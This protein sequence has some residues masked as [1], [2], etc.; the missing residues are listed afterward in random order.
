M[1]FFNG[2]PWT[3]FQEQNLDWII[4]ELKKLQEQASDYE[5][6]KQ[7]VTNWIQD[8]DVPA[9]VAAQIQELIDNGTIEQMIQDIGI[10]QLFDGT[11]LLPEQFKTDNNTWD[12]AFHDLAGA[13]DQKIVIPA[14][15]Y[16]LTTDH[17]L[18][19]NVIS[20]A[21]IY[22]NKSAISPEQ[23]DVGQYAHLR[24]LNKW[25]D[26]V[27]NLQGACKHGTIIAFVT[28]ENS[29]NNVYIHEYTFSNMSFIRSLLV[30]PTSAI[31]G[32]NLAWDAVNNRYLVAPSYAVNTLYAVDQ[33]GNVQT[34]TIP[35]GDVID[36]VCAIE[37][38]FLIGR[39]NVS[40]F[41][42][43]SNLDVIREIPITSLPAVPNSNNYTGYQSMY[44]YKGSLFYMMS[45]FSL[46][47]EI[48][49]F[50]IWRTGL[51]NIDWKIFKEY[52][53]NDHFRGEEAEAVVLDDDV[54]YVFSYCRNYIHI[55]YFNTDI[56]Y[57]G[58]DG[59]INTIYVDET[60]SV[61]GIGTSSNPFNSLD[62]AMYYGR[63]G[64]GVNASNCVQ[65]TNA[66]IKNYKGR[67][68]G[69][70]LT[71]EGIW[72]GCDVFFNAGSFKTTNKL[73]LRQTRFCFDAGGGWTSDR[74]VGGYNNELIW[75]ELGSTIIFRGM[76]FTVNDASII[77]IRCQLNGIFMG[78]M[79][80]NA[81]NNIETYYGGYVFWQD[82]N[83][84]SKVN[85]RGQAL[86]VI[87]TT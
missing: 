70:N 79:S 23:F 7:Y 71:L 15:T 39:H 26:P 83:Q 67:I 38:G 20:N 16:P 24:S 2:W 69:T 9:E 36:V 31:H 25:A 5:E 43:A 53:Y 62:E 48:C 54:L 81:T 37:N 13:G 28:E 65:P 40:L 32:N 10:A 60:L 1:A 82:K 52:T 55:M 74:T 29:D 66:Y 3:Q 21:G 87:A 57:M 50:T 64:I 59:N 47:T 30:G 14:K 6:F 45:T 86:I 49:G 18:G 68:Y 72:Y 61:D 12:D 4:R 11:F 56:T 27:Y 41:Q 75:L 42:C 33:L 73:S 22:P 8:L 76:A 46:T 80:S 51:A 77:P 63:N 78:D 44:Y 85:Q 84:A 58:V 34:L 35:T 17:Y 19:D